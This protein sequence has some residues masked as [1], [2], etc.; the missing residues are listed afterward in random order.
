MTSHEVKLMLERLTIEQGVRI[1][2]LHSVSV[3]HD[4]TCSA[5]FDITPDP[6]GNGLYFEFSLPQVLS[7]N[8]LV[9]FTQWLAGPTCE[10]VH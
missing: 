8:D 4:T 7:R 2:G 3:M 6:S 5:I 10:T 1:T 9:S